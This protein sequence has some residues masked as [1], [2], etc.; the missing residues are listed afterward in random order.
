[1][2]KKPTNANIAPPNLSCESL[3][4]FSFSNIFLIFVG[5]KAYKAPSIKKIKPIAIINSS[6]IT[7]FV[8]LLIFGLIDLPK[9]LKKSLSGDKTSDVS[10][11]INAFSYACI[12]L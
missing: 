12:A 1:M 11:P 3:I 5:N 4:N 6:T 2:I 7:N 9:N 8:Y 10:P